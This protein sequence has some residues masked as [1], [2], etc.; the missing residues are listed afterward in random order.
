MEKKK[1]MFVGGGDLCLQILKMLVPRDNF[2]FY[3]A[4]RD[5]EHVTRRCNLLR[6]GALQL[7]GA[8]TVYPVVMDLAEG[9]IEENARTVYW[10]RPDIIFN[11]ASLQSW[12][13]MTQLPLEHYQALNKAG[14]GPW[15]PMHL[16]PAYE[17][18]RAIKR[19]GI[20]V[21]TVN[22]AFPDAVNV[23]L[24]KVGMAPDTGIGG[25]ANMIPAIRLA[26][27]RLAMRPPE[28]VQ[29]RLVAQQGFCQ[30]VAHSGLAPDAQYRLTYWVDN[31]DRTGEFTDE[32]IFSAVCTN[33]RSL[34]GVD[35]NFFNAISAVRLLENLHAEHEIITHVPGPNGL[36]GGYPV[37]VGL[38]QVLLA[39]PYGVSRSDAIAVNQS[40]QR[41]DGISAVH[42]DGSVDF[43]SENMA[44]MEALLGFTVSNLKLQDVHQ[45]AAELG[46]KYKSFAD[47]VR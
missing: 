11:S 43:E 18:M 46:H 29:V 38:G 41:Q 23:V 12:R 17:L 34:G 39:L 13:M 21:V 42:A 15:L 7:G 40:G 9:H 30:Q 6:L 2:I 8:C 1:L 36:P 45:Y 22:A 27:G 5:L 4:G 19:S 32:V 37:R 31:L 44:V 16:A 35:I 47:S 20:K 25:I 28:S 14:F 33:F 3:V 10:I 24:D 26:I